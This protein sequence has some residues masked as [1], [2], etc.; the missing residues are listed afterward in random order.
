[1]TS[2]I[3]D[4]QERTID[5]LTQQLTRLREENSRMGQVNQELSAKLKDATEYNQA[6]GLDLYRLDQQISDIEDKYKANMNRARELHL[7]TKEMKRRT[8]D[9]KNYLGLDSKTAAMAKKLQLLQDFRDQANIGLS[10]LQKILSNDKFNELPY[11]SQNLEERIHFLFWYNHDLERTVKKVSKKIPEEQIDKNCGSPEEIH[12]TK[13]EW[14]KIKLYKCLSEQNGEI[15]Q[16]DEEHKEEENK[17]EEHKEE[18][19][20]GEEHKEEE[21][22]NEEKKDEEKPEAQEEPKDEENK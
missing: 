13:E 6:L 9:Y 12:R 16:A 20:K 14:E 7:K 2:T 4:D 11:S 21:N 22:K 10:E 8:D 3:T 5:E 19:T 18:E 1:M 17:D 15:V